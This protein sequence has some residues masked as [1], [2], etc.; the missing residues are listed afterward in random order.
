MP[1][2]NNTEI[3][4]KD[5]NKII[6][7]ENPIKETILY[8]IP[9]GAKERTSGKEFPEKNNKNNYHNRNIDFNENKNAM[10]FTQK[11]KNL[12]VNYN[13]QRYNSYN[14]NNSN[15]K[16]NL[17]QMNENNN[18]INVYNNTDQNLHNKNIYSEKSNQN[19]Y[20]YINYNIINN[21]VNTSRTIAKAGNEGD[22]FKNI[23][24]VCVSINNNYNYNVSL[25][26]P[27]MQPEKYNDLVMRISMGLP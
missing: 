27:Q 17:N 18:A 25:E 1:R 26:T 14:N 7:N 9:Y 15:N 8:N 12:P 21:N 16:M 2:Y 23:N 13:I 20:N 11:T 5:K 4:I 24:S 3:K 19:Q 22:A 10:D 6:K